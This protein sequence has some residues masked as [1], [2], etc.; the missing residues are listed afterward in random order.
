M[1]RAFAV[2]FLAFLLA[3]G[4]A[5]GQTVVIN[6]FSGGSLPADWIKASGDW[7]VKSGELVQADS[8]EMM[9][10]LNI[11]A[12][13]SGVVQYEFDL[14]YLDGAQDDYA[15]FGFHIMVSDPSR[16]RSWGDGVS[17][18]LWLTW[19]KAAY[20]AGIFAQAYASTGATQMTLYPPRDIVKAGNNLPL[21]ASY[22]KPEFLRVTIPVKIV[23]DT[24]AGELKVY[25]PLD[26]NYFYRF[27]AEMPIKSGK[28]FALR[29]NSLSV[30]LDNL[31]VTKLE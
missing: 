27:R 1:K 30:A 13:Q 14:R 23:V 10:V 15:G 4:I 17:G 20:G 5:L 24:K 28:Y 6:S 29:T 25:D 21:P 18:L 8:K 2:G 11:P 31:K 22:L 12:D 19:D 26:M 3:A 9:A 7:Q 16:A